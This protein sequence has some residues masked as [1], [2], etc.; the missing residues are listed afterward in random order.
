MWTQPAQRQ[1]TGSKRKLIKM[2]ISSLNKLVSCRQFRYHFQS[3][4]FATVLIKPVQPQI[5][6][7][8][9]REKRKLAPQ[10]RL[11][12]NQNNIISNL[13]QFESQS[14]TNNKL[15]MAA[16]VITIGLGLA[17]PVFASETSQHGVRQIYDLAQE[18]EF[19]SNVVRYIRF[20]ITVMLGTGTVMLKPIQGILKN[21]VSAVIFISVVVLAGIGLKFTLNAMLGMDES[22]DLQG[23]SL[24][25]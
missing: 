6:Q 8:N 11:D 17:M 13:S 18:Q 16:G 3:R 7:S 10:S 25:Q 1:R 21:P 14:L 4:Q 19:W 23:V 9:R 2:T 20:F 15:I 5:S 24:I 12:E 22:V